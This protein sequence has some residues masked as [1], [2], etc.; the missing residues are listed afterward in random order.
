M[1]LLNSINKKSVFWSAHT[2]V[3]WSV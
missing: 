2:W 3:E 1:V